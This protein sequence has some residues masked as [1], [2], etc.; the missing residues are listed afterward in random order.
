M[1]KR[2]GPV[3]IK[4]SEVAYREDKSLPKIIIREWQTKK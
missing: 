1:D 4:A 2:G 3:D